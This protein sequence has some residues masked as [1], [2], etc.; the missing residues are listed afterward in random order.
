MGLNFRPYF[1]LV[2]VK[3]WPKNGVVFIPI[4]LSGD[5]LISHKLVDV[6][7]FFLVFSLTSSIVYCFNDILDRDSDRYHPKKKFRPLAAGNL[8]V[9]NAL[10]VIVVLFCAILFIIYFGQFE[11][12]AISLVIFYLMVNLLY[13]FW[14]KN[15][16]LLDLFFVSSGFVIRLQAGADIIV[17]ELSNWLF[18][19]MGV[20]S[21]LV[22][23]A[24]RKAD[25]NLIE[26]VECQ[27]KSVMRYSPTFL[28]DLITLLSS[29]AIILYMIFAMS[30]HAIERYGANL[31][32]SIPIFMFVIFRYVQLSNID[33]GLD[34]PTTAF[35][36][37][38][39]L[40]FGLLTFIVSFCFLVY[41]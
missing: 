10:F 11:N 33:S 24:K 32:Y 41:L 3:Q 28:A 29:S 6:I 31:V 5:I 1:N 15:L 14:V 4:F 20:C 22:V 2:R 9:K 8:T 18:L 34:E 40:F 37:D 30:D 27:R 23:C 35:F 13:S 36:S 12:R 39:L 26:S 38:K 19:I 17:L 16:N 7:L 25:I 21:M